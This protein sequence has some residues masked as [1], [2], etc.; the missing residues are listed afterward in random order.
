MLFKLLNKFSSKPTLTRTF[1]ESKSLL[2]EAKG[3][4]S[5]LFKL[6]KSTGYAL[7]K[8]KEAL[9]KHDGNI[10]AASKWLDEQAQ[11]EGWSKAEKLKNRQTKQGTL[12]LYADKD[13]NKATIVELNCETDF[14]A[15]NEKFLDLSSH[16]AKSI[17]LNAQVDRSKVSFNG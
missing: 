14:V 17:L 12:V 13:K 7:S 8:C 10:E 6:R 1:F 9:E 16:L 11:K 4:N 3:S 15:R 5:N 2:Q